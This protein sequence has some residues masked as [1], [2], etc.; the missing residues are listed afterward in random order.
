MKCPDCG[1]RLFRLRKERNRYECRN[2]R[3]PVIE[4]RLSRQKGTQALCDA[5]L[6]R[7]RRR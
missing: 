4:V 7:K 5:A 3:C 1:S 6:A 2:E